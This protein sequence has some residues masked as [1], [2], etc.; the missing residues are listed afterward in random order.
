MAGDYEMGRLIQTAK[1]QRDVLK[2]LFN[3]WKRDPL[4]VVY[5]AD[6]LRCGTLD[7]L[8]KRVALDDTPPVVLGD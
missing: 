3:L 7:D 2:F 4:G 5:A 8:K 6:S 1:I